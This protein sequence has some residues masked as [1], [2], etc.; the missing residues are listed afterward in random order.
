MTVAYYP[1]SSRYMYVVRLSSQLPEHLLLGFLCTGY[2]GF[3]YD[4]NYFGVERSA[5]SGV[6]C[7]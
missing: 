1:V 7:I 3:R 4:I 6:D 5:E 2:K